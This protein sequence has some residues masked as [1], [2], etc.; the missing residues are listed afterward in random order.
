[1]RKKE[2]SETDFWCFW[3]HFGISWG[4]RRE[5]KVQKRDF[6]RVPKKGSNEKGRKTSQIDW[7][8]AK[9][10]H[11]SINTSDQYYSIHPSSPSSV[12]LIR[13]SSHAGVK[14]Q[15]NINKTNNKTSTSNQSSNKN[16]KKKTIENHQKSINTTSKQASGSC[17][18]SR[19][20]KIAQNA[21]RKFGWSPEIPL[22]TPKSGKNYKIEY[23]NR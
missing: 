18:G 16:H 17:K 13:V 6:R 15:E 10:D 7:K 8:P 5:T 11:P 4:P 21:V 2:P 12:A 23:K 19:R 3:Q 14:D 9:K 20:A 22:E 1:M